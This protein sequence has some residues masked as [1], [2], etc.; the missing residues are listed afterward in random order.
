VSHDS[1]IINLYYCSY[2]GIKITGP[3]G[4]FGSYEFYIKRNH[5]IS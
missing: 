1:S 4:C 5:T 3:I 2:E